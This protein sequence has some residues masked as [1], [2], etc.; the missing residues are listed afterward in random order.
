MEEQVAA[1]GD[2]V[3]SLVASIE[4]DLKSML[5]PFLW[6]TACVPERKTEP[7]LDR[8]LNDNS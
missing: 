4:S 2:A 8:I 1:G 6:P 3:A 5:K 7:I